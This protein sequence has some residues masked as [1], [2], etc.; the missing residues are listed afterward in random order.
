MAHL[1]T[2]PDTTPEVVHEVEIEMDP[3]YSQMMLLINSK[4][5]IYMFLVSNFVI[6]LCASTN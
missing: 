3:L 6:F 4:S 1:W 2:I 5:L